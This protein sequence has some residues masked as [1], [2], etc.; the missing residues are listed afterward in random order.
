MSSVKVTPVMPIPKRVNGFSIDSI[1]R[2]DS[3][4]PPASSGDESDAESSEDAA[5]HRPSSHGDYQAHA[6]S[7][8]ARIP[9]LHP[10]LPAHVQHLLLRDSQSGRGGSDLL[11][12]RAQA[13]AFGSAN[14]SGLPN[15]GFGSPPGLHSFTTQFAAPL[16][17]IPGGLPP[18]PGLIAAA[19]A[20][21]RDPLSMY[22]PWMLNKQTPGIFGYPFGHPDGGLFFHPYRK[23][24]R[25]RTAFS[26][27]QLLKL[28]HAFEKNHYVV[29]QERKELAS[30][31]N[32]TETQVKVWFQ[33]R[34]TKHKR[35]KS[36]DDDD[37]DEEGGGDIS[38]DDD[39]PEPTSGSANTES[40]TANSSEIY[41]Q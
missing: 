8:G 24:K 1:M 41:K 20:M 26:P 16:G 22:P 37:D 29:G 7:V 3:D 23:P 38:V 13:L 14:F 10:S 30:K 12:L 28:E 2:K 39:E 5:P 17:S 18:H 11:S 6:Q 15:L 25:I 19:A 4:R 34:R 40:H 31:L 35:V 21:G 36:D 27:S 33:N 9:P 32:L